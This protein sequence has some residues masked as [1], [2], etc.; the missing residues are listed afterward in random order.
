MAVSVLHMVAERNRAWLLKA[1]KKHWII[2]FVVMFAQACELVDRTPVYR[3]AFSQCV[4]SDAWRQ[5]MLEEMRRELSF[6]E[7]IEFIYRDANNSSSRQIE[8][9][10]ELLTMQPD[11]II[12]S[13][14][15]AEPLTPVVDEIFRSG[16]PVIVTDRKTSSGLYHAYVGADNYEIGFMAGQYLARQLN[17]Q[18]TISEVTGLP[19]SSAAIE[20]QK[21]FHDALKPFPGIRVL[22]QIN[23]RWLI[24][25]ARS[26]VA[27]RANTLAA[28]EAIFAY[29]DQMALGTYQ[30]LQKVLPGN[31]IKIVGVDALPGDNNGLHFV[32]EK[33]LDASMLYPTGG[34]E[35]I[36]TAMAILNNQP[37][38]RENIL[39]TLVVDSANVQLMKL[40]TDK[41]IS[42]QAAIDKQQ[43]LYAEQQRIFSNQQRVLNILV[44]SLVLAVVFAG[45]S[46]YSL[47]AN[48]EKNKQLEHQNNEILGQQQRILEMTNEV[49]Q[50]T[51]AKI[52]FFTN[53]S[54][55]FKT[56]LSLMIVPLDDLL[57][58]GK[59][60]ED[61]RQSLALIKKNALILQHLVSQLIDLRRMGYENLRIKANKGNILLFC[62]HIVQSFRP[63]AQQKSV[64]FRLENDATDTMLWFDEDLMEKLLYNLLS[65]AFKFT[66]P[67]G[68]IVLRLAHGPTD[69]KGFEIQVIDTGEGI[70]E[71]DI[72][73]L[74]EPFYQGESL[75]K[76]TGIGLSLCKEIAALHRGS[77]VVHSEKGRGTRVTVALPVGDSHLDEEE[78]AHQP[79][80]GATGR[81]IEASPFLS[82]ILACETDARENDDLVDAPDSDIVKAHS[83][84]I[85]ED[86]TEMRLFLSE[87]LSEQFTVFT[88]ADAK[89]G[90]NQAYAQLP[91]LIISDVLMPGELGTVLVEKLKADVRT[92]TIPIILLTARGSAEQ[93]VTGLDLLADAYL[94]KP[95][96]MDYLLALSNNLINNRKLLHRHFSSD[97]LELRPVS[98]TVP[99]DRRFLNELA[100]LVEENIDNSGL[101]VDYLCE[102]L[103]TSRIQLYRKVKTLLDCSINDYISARRLRKA[104]LLLQQGIPINSVAYQT[105]FSSPAYFSTAFKSKY[106]MS[107]SIF[108]K[109]LVDAAG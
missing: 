94:T 68:E 22:D 82:T 65:N 49:E 42:Q 81:A 88:A 96:D 30:A 70:S 10:R 51:E 76:G 79:L 87:K 85:V 23:G 2:L 78:K 32:A 77:I 26:R 108:K 53:I 74:F 21:G 34:K 37:Y 17:R 16:I 19:G 20:R 101:N 106:G 13:P 99:A 3:I 97:V 102:R 55:E 54:H 41:V 80:L 44:V 61:T 103:G 35:C 29:N 24:D 91:D 75:A 64:N 48:W 84:L 7:H 8:Q 43:L 72:A 93:M 1:M 107:P 98:N 39:S 56:P 104:K 60:P 63:L 12:V 62:S 73:H 90:L 109:H 58:N 9:L 86:H 15:E 14:N 66:P 100:A 31:R 38:Q 95:F 46:F 33:V 92:A 45:I 11:L 47:K 36:Q 27:Q 28:S 52:N 6:Y 5:T 4:G 57:R 25:E 69:R 71:V 89:E 67:H 18:G 59:L 105:G 40:Q 83:I 50:A